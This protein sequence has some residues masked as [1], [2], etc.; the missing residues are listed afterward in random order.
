[1]W[2]ITAGNKLVSDMR[3]PYQWLTHGLELYPHSTLQPHTPQLESHTLHHLISVFATQCMSDTVYDNLVA[4]RLIK[5]PVGVE[6]VC[7]F[8]VDQKAEWV[9]R[10]L[11]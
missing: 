6:G 8:G 2:I 9:A 5:V 11:G 3:S 1:M 7:S 10:D 4:L